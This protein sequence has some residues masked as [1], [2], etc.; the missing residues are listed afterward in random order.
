[1]SLTFQEVSA[2]RDQVS[3]LAQL[4][5]NLNTQASYS[6]IPSGEPVQQDDMKDVQVEQVEVKP[7]DLFRPYLTE[8]LSSRMT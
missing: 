6:A 2:L 5:R 3:E 8:S 1:M 7:S 4:L